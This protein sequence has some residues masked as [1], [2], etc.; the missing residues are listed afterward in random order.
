MLALATALSACGG[1]SAAGGSPDERADET[2]ELGQQPAGNEPAPG[3]EPPGPS[4]AQPRG[5]IGAP[6][7]PAADGVPLPPQETIVQL[8][9]ETARVGAGDEVTTHPLFVARSP[10][11]TQLELVEASERICVRGELALVPNADYANFWGGEVGLILGSSP[12]TDVAPPGEGLA[13]PG[14]SFR[15]A[16]ELPPQLRLRV[17]A[18]GE[19]PLTSQYCQTVPANTD[20]SIEMALQSLSF[21]CWL[22][23]GA[24]F[25]ADASATLVSWQIPA[26]EGAASAFDFCIEDIRALP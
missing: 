22:P 11:G 2:S 8:T 9:S 10:L 1:N 21:E 5:A 17:A 13:T 16:G 18:S 19:A 4:P 14:F 15:L 12:A 3:I 7:E 23:D 20:A 24:Q 25:P 26:N 6:A